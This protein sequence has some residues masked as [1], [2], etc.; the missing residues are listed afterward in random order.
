MSRVRSGPHSRLTRWAVR[1]YTGREDI[2]VT[3]ENVQRAALGPALLGVLA[4]G[5]ACDTLTGDGQG[6]GG[7]AGVASWA[8][9]VALAGGLVG[10]TA[11]GQ[12]RLTLYWS[13]ENGLVHLVPKQ[14]GAYA[15]V[16][17]SGGLAADLVVDEGT[18]F[19]LDATWGRVWRYDV[20]FGEPVV[21]AI[22]QSPHRMA[23]DLSHVYWIND[24]GSVLRVPRGGGYPQSVASGLHEFR[25]I[26][27]DE[28]QLYLTDSMLGSVVAIP[29]G[30]GPMMTLAQQQDRPES[31]TLDE[32]HVYWST[33]TAIM[34]LDLTEPDAEPEVVTQGLS[35]PTWLTAAGGHL[36]WSNTEQGQVLRVPKTGGAAEPI[37]T[38]QLQPGALVVDTAAVYWVNRGDGGQD[39]AVVKATR[40]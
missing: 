19:W 3:R 7:P 13:D 5:S 22:G 10:P 33:A 18:V 29:L 6:G 9:P 15:S 24:S 2:G 37:A 30:G 8:E 20:E 16:A 40:Q 38:G 17:G 36:Y 12:D 14:G 32:E 21:L 34:S 26:A 28:F 1:A 11:I 35:G 23:L 27:L 4:L 25:D 39:G 31:V